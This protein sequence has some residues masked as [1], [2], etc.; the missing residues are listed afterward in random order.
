M[1]ISIRRILFPT[2]FSPSAQTAQNYAIAFA[3]TF[4][5]ELHLLHVV[6]EP[7]LPVRGSKF[8]WAVPDDVIPRLVHAA[9]LELAVRTEASMLKSDS[10]VQTIKVGQ[11]VS[12][13]IQYANANKIDLIVI[14]T[15]G[16]TG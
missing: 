7:V 12:E 9:E 10:V 14:G 5:A 16:H 11:P 13:I 6:P 4:G 3:K 15:H 2:D 1:S 8:S